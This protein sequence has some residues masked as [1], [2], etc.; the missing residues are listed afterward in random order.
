[1]HTSDM[2]AVI[3]YFRKR[4]VK[5]VFVIGHSYGGPTALLSK[6]QDF[7]A[8][9]LWDPSYNLKLRSAKYG[10]RYVKQLNGYLM[11]TWGI[12]VVLGRKMVEESEALN[13]DDMTKGF[14]VPLKIISAGKG[15]IVAGA[16][17]YFYHAHGPKELT[18]VKG[19]THYF[20]DNEG[21]RE[22]IFRISKKWFESYR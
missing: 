20:D 9:V 12:N 17:K 21:M 18:I 4:G 22:E 15:E 11:D 13:W 5:K 6:D 1:M 14:H 16:K 8:A 10:G 19:A 7:D 3:H 2:D